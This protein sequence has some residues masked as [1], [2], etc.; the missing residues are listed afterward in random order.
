MLRIFIKFHS[1][2]KCVTNNF[3]TNK[4]WLVNIYI[5]ICV[6]EIFFFVCFVV[7]WVGSADD[8]ASLR[9]SILELGEDAVYP[10]LVV[11]IVDDCLAE[12]ASHY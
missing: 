1:F 3:L 5:F 7:V 12:D 11:N 8:A 6:S 4:A 10:L 9:E 2:S